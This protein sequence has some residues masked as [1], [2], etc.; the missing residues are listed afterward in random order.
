MRL[1][2]NATGRTLIG[3][4]VSEEGEEEMGRNKEYDGGKQVHY[5]VSFCQKEAS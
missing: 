1:D 4:A 3:Q 2:E 5:A